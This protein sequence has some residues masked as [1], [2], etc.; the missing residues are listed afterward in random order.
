MIFLAHVSHRLLKKLFLFSL[1]FDDVASLFT[2]ALNIL[3]QATLEPKIGPQI[4]P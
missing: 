1:T 3:Q 4:S 2:V